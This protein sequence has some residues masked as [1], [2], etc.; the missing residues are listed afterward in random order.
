MSKGAKKEVIFPVLVTDRFMRKS[1]Y[2]W[3]ILKISPRPTS[4]SPCQTTDS[5]Y[6]T[7]SARVQLPCYPRPTQFKL[8][9]LSIS[10]P[11]ALYFQTVIQNNEPNMMGLKTKHLIN[12]NTNLII[13][14]KSLTN[15][16][17]IQNVTHTS[18]L[19]TTTTTTC[20]PEMCPKCQ[21]CPKPK[22]HQDWSWPW[23]TDTYFGQNGTV[24]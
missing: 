13:G 17:H 11:N 2:F 15:K 18:Y 3:N 9:F 8:T 24:D 23:S 4:H 19:E 7:V 12:K 21:Q 10:Q 16:I 6:Y 14:E 5:C 20:R 22:R 1:I